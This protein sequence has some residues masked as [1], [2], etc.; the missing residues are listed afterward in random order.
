[1]IPLAAELLKLN[2]HVIIA[3]GEEHLNLIRSELPGCT[4]MLFPGFNPRYSRYMPQYL[5][6][7]LK[8]PLLAYHVFL[9]HIRLRKIIKKY[10][11]DIVISDN[12]FGLW[13]RGIKSVYVTH[14]LL[15]P[16]PGRLKF[17]EPA[18]IFLHSLIIR[19][20]NLCFIPDL[21]GE[22]NI[23]GRLSHG[24][25]IPGNVRYIGILSRFML[26]NQ[27][28]CLP[29]EKKYNTVI[30]SGPEPQKEI[31][32]QKLIRLFSDKEPPTIMLEGKPGKEVIKRRSGNIT[33]YN[34]LASDQLRN[35]ITGSELVVSR[36]GYTTIMDLVALNCSA[37]LIP[38]PGQTEQEY[39]AEYL[40]EQGLFSFIRQR[41]AG[42]E[43]AVPEKKSYNAYRITEE[44]RKLLRLAL[45]ELLSE[46]HK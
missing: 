13:N 22:R 32:K 33:I 25:R 38:T 31:L 19:K 1:M 46:P 45:S 40:T 28:V 27:A 44:S 10:S 29:E 18:G 4:F 3:S 16:F 23:S 17:M 41:D 11:V 35:V 43:I 21:P 8:I 7:F 42:K 39:L 26:N 2:H 9:E 30:L 24:I 14:M 20:Y 12:R 36:S 5:S 15:I 6:M 34:H 37:L